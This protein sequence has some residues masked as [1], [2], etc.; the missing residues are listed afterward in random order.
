METALT[1]SIIGTTTGAISMLISLFGIKHNRFLA[2]D[3]FL[4]KIEDKDFIQ[5]KKHVYTADD[6]SD[7][8]DEDFA[9]IVNFFHHW[10]ML[11]KKHHLPLWVFDHATGAGACRLYD[12]VENYIKNR[13]SV[14]NDPTYGEYF[15]WLYKKLIR[16]TK[17]QDFRN[18]LI[19]FIRS[20]IQSVKKRIGTH[21][22]HSS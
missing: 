21:N 7:I 8:E 1:L 12:R 5:A 14:N 17:Q 11:V 3:K 16:R 4:S 19:K 2:A 9:I 18:K 20:P 22:S 6:V 10:G 13:R 15:E